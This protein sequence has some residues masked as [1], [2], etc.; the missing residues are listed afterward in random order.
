MNESDY[1]SQES[2]KIDRAREII[3]EKDI[4]ELREELD[5]R[6]LYER[7]YLAQATTE[8]EIEYKK[9][10]NELQTTLQKLS[11]R[12]EELEIEIKYLKSQKV[13][14]HQIAVVL[15]DL[16]LQVMNKK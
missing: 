7:D 6:I 12:V 15:S 13:D 11:H 16:S 2:H 8:K 9:E 10:L 4:V 14:M 1:T 5:R 3:L